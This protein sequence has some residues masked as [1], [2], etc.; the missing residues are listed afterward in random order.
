MHHV[1]AS[2]YTVVLV[3]AAVFSSGSI[4]GPL[5]DIQSLST[6]L[7]RK[8]LPYCTDKLGRQFPSKVDAN[9][10]CDD[11]DSV[12][13]N[14]LLCASGE[15]AG[16]V[17]VANSQ[18]TAATL[19]KRGAWWRSPRIALEDQ[20][21][22]APDGKCDSFSHDQGLGVLLTVVTKRTD[23][24]YVTRLSDW[25]TWIDANRPC[26]V[27]NEPLCVRFWPRVCRDDTE[28]PNWPFKGCSM[29][30][31]DF[32]MMQTVLPRLGLN[33]IPDPNP[34]EDVLSKFNGWGPM[35]VVFGAGL[36]DIGYPMHLAAAGIL[37]LTPLVKNNDEQAD[38]DFAASLLHRRQPKNAFYSYLAGAPREDTAKLVLE[39]CPKTAADIPKDRTQW[40]WERADGSNA[41]LSTMLWDCV[42]MANM[43]AL[44]H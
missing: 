35:F 43:L 33:M 38:L 28:P 36:N 18:D 3:A 39:S 29:R 8:N 30:P 15:D 41:K 14:G 11:R 42:F 7:W 26:I 10:V 34:L 13:F 44:P 6:N 32:A 12:I 23:P 17:A 5:E 27:G 9:G 37:I 19:P 2:I 21:C 16:C 31:G 40:I 20:K 24:K 4:A 25:M 22:T 1:A